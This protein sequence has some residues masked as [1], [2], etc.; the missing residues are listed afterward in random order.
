MSLL[1]DPVAAAKVTSCLKEVLHLSKKVDTARKASEESLSEVD[2]AQ[3]RVR[4]EG[5][6]NNANK[7]RLKAG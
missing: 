1:S 3:R 2:A 7:N 5:K 4:N 6:I